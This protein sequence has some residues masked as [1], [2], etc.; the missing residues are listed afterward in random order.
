MPPKGARKTKRAAV[1]DPNDAE[2]YVAWMARYLERLRG[3]G[4]TRSGRVETPRDVLSA[5]SSRGATARPCTGPQEVTKPILERYQRHLFHYPQDGRQ[6]AL[7]LERS[8]SG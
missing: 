2:G 4:A 8:A 6:A 3:A 1:G 5:S 7:V